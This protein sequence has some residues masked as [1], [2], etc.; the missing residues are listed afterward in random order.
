MRILSWLLCVYC[1]DLYRFVSKKG[2]E[3]RTVS[4]SVFKYQNRMIFPAFDFWQFVLRWYSLNLQLI[5]VR[6]IHDSRTNDSFE[7]VPYSES[8][9]KPRFPNKRLLWAGPCFLITH[10]SNIF[11][12]QCRANPKW[13]LWTGSLKWIKNKQR[14]RCTPI[15]KPLILMSRLFSGEL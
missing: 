1:I 12:D 6:S 4:D 15:R 3:P 7:P 11:R 8:K 5:S 9:A 2:W 14:D 10:F 13:F